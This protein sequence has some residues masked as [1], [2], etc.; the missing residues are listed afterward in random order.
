MNQKAPSN[1]ELFDD[2]KYWKQ[3]LKKRKASEQQ[4]HLSLYSLHIPPVNVCI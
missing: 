3:V 2:E 4:E 1:M